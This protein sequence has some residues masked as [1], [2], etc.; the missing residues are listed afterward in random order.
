MLGCS[1]FTPKQV[2][3]PHTG[4]SQPIWI[5]F[6]IHLLLYRIHLWANL[7]CDWRV[8]GSGPNQSN[9]L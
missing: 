9:F 4:K 7:D 2:L 8:G 6:C 1:V 5:K 3:D